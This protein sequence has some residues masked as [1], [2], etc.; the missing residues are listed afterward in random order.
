MKVSRRLFLRC[1][2]AGAGALIMGARIGLA[3]TRNITWK[4]TCRQWMGVL[5]PANEYGPGADTPIVWEYMEKLL[6][7][8][9]Q[10][11]Q[12]FILGMKRLGNQPIPRS[13]QELIMMQKT[14]SPYAVIIR[15]MNKL[16]VE[17][18][19]ASSHGWREIGL[20]AAAQPNGFS[21]NG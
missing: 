14:G 20:S 7:E 15:F 9:P 16:F 8:K 10:T 6:E 12:W 3:K 1:G 4:D 13:P 11:R 17:Y 21:L 2:V 5:L 18:Y 19:F